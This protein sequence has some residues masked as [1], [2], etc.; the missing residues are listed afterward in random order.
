VNSA[1]GFLDDVLDDA[2]GGAADGAGKNAFKSQELL[3]SHYAKHVGEFGNV[4]KDQYLKGAQN[5]VNSNSG[6]NILT[7]PRTNGDTLF[8]NKATNEFAVKASD[9]TIR[10]YFKPTDG[11]NHNRSRIRS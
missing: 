1:A 9:G 4:T 3:D 10:T 2:V 7:K 8:Y 6:G 11:I 5:L